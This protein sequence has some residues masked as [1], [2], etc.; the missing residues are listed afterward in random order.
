MILQKSQDCFVQM[1]HQ[2]KVRELLPKLHFILLL[3][4]L[5]LLTCGLPTISLAEIKLNLD[6]KVV[7]LNSD[8][9]P[10]FYLE[11][12]N[13]SALNEV[14]LEAYILNGKKYYLKDESVERVSVELKRAPG[15][16]R[17]IIIL[18]NS[19]SNHLQEGE[20][21]LTIEVR[22]GKDI[23]AKIYARIES[24]PRL[25][26]NIA[27]SLTR[28]SEGRA[29][30]TGSRSNLNQ[31]LQIA[32]E[33]SEV[34]S[35]PEALTSGTSICSAEF[36]FI[37]PV[38]SRVQSSSFE[39]LAIDI[40]E[41]A[42]VI[43]GTLWK[44]PRFMERQVGRDLQ[45]DLSFYMYDIA[46]GRLVRFSRNSTIGGASRISFSD[47]IVPPRLFEPFIITA[48]FNPILQMW[49]TDMADTGQTLTDTRSGLQRLYQVL[50]LREHQDRLV[51]LPTF[52]RGNLT[53][54]EEVLTGIYHPESG[55]IIAGSGL[56][57]SNQ[58]YTWVFEH[59]VMHEIGHSFT[60][61]H[62]HDE[63]I[64]HK[65]AFPRDVMSYDTYGN[66]AFSLRHLRVLD[67]FLCGAG[68]S[69]IDYGSQLEF[70][71]RHECN[72]IGSG[73][74]DCWTSVERFEK[75]DVPAG[76]DFNNL[77]CPPLTNF[78]SGGYERKGK[79][80][81]EHLHFSSPM[82]EHPSMYSRCVDEAYYQTKTYSIG[83]FKDDG[84]YQFPLGT[85]DRFSV[86]SNGI[87]R[88]SLL[89]LE[90][91]KYVEHYPF[92]LEDS[93]SI[94]SLSRIYTLKE[95][96]N[97]SSTVV[98]RSQ[99]LAE[100]ATVPFSVRQGD[101]IEVETRFVSGGHQVFDSP[102]HAISA[103]NGNY[104]GV[105]VR[106]RTPE[107]FGLGGNFN[108]SL[109]YPEFEFRMDRHSQAPLLKIDGDVQPILTTGGY[110]A[111]EF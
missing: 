4:T 49:G 3:L 86:R 23:E 100:A 11:D 95:L 45:L 78:T 43:D 29:V 77:T 1:L 17:H 79:L 25:I 26:N 53:Y 32:G 94:P 33:V 108:H 61:A 12:S 39:D 10:S 21:S 56:I 16:Y 41:V 70:A 98:N 55:M 54:P 20:N 19:L 34:P 72:E 104:D 103:V 105:R 81:K 85:I 5:V 44:L 76:G 15:K 28:I 30:S 36:A 110:L 24:R 101:I 51:F 80:P 88:V 13:G 69:E 71:L 83:G 42:Q 87:I 47:I 52:V 67:H 96:L 35:G 99:W 6:G 14:H 58:K 62:V 7:V 90:E 91:P 40:A 37:F 60:L 106:I 92:L 38:D 48:M 18:P 107:D 57:L 89:S 9:S 59:T 93:T 73:L 111:G 65:V 68:K 74:G 75:F 50:G 2:I 102:P 109:G 97:Q 8:V 66:T 82:L 64:S 46:D 31:M 84:T 63:L 22:G 27:P